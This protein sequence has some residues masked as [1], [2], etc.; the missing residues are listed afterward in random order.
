[1]GSGVAADA[2]AGA[3]V[4][5]GTLLDMKPDAAKPQTD[6]SKPQIT[7]GGAHD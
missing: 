5:A 1:V 2:A 3:A 7:D 6:A 4:D